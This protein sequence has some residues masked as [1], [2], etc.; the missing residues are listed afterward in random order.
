[1]DTEVGNLVLG[2]EGDLDW[3]RISGVADPI[4]PDASPASVL[5]ANIDWLATLRGRVGLTAGNALL[6]ATAGVA[7]GGV[8]GTITNFPSGNSITSI[9]GTQYG[10]VVGAGIEAGLAPH[11]TGKLEVLRIDLGT[12][13]YQ[14]PP[15]M[16]ADA[17]PIANVI[18][19]SLNYRF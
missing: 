6:F 13:T 14:L 8:S 2:I 15:V 1:V 17:H 18:Q 11:L 4:K 5:T 16:S 3:T 19:L 12:A 10:T 7:G 9:G